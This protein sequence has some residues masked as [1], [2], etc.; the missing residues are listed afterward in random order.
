MN[1]TLYNLAPMLYLLLPT[2]ADTTIT[3]NIS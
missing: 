1:E 2:A 3:T